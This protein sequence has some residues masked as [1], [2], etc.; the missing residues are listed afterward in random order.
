MVQ[1]GTKPSWQM[2]LACLLGLGVLFYASYGFSNW[3][4]SQRTDVSSIVFPWENSVVFLAWTIVPYWTTN[5]FYAASPFL[6][7][8]RAE[9][10]SHIKR[11]VT[12]QVISVFCFIAFPLKFSWPKPDTSGVFNFLYEGLALFDKPFNQAPSLHVAL[13]IILASLY[14]KVLPKWGCILFGAWSALVII[15]VMTTYQHHFI[16]IPTG[17]LLGLFCVWLWPSDGGRRVTSWRR[18]R[19]RQ[20]TLAWCYCFGAGVFG[21]AAYMLQGGFLWMLWPAFALLAVS[22]AYLGLGAAVFDKNPD[23]RIG[24]PSRIL[25]SPYLV[26]AR[27]NSRLWTRKE[28]KTVEIVDG[29]H[30]G[31][32]P[33][34]D[35]LAGFA[36][37]VDLT[38]E[39][40]RPCP[41]TRW[42]SIPMMDLVATAPATLAMAADA[43]EQARSKGPVL[44]VCALGYGRS[45]GTLVV[46]L[47]RTGRASG[48]AS[49]LRL[50]SEK[51]P[52]LTLSPE[53][54]ASIT[55][56]IHG[57]ET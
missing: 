19:G 42:I 53:Q 25:L 29:V 49:A 31:R 5:L 17:A 39:F 41:T 47:V 26:A 28:K 10:A 55:E 18:A 50:L 3:L 34:K 4:A 15:S 30:L 14:L 2:A 16:D 33:D 54:M 20:L 37:V 52:K 38:C 56:A 44:V 7:R 9:F 23:G 51:R 24:W 8:T 1:E 13:T 32:F 40:S 22:L 21:L 43:I 35:D 12:A 6:C 11:L 45:V 57:Q 48:I 36:T 27:L 46:W